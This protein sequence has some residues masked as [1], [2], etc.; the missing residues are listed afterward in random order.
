MPSTTKFLASAALGLALAC[1]A[2]L[3]G[4]AKDGD[5]DSSGSS[6]GDALVPAAACRPLGAATAV[7]TGAYGGV[8]AVENGAA[9]DVA[10]PLATE[11]LDGG[12]PVTF[13]VAYVD[14][15]A[16][17]AGAGVTAQ[18][19][20]T[21]YDA[22]AAQGYKETPVPGCKWTSGGS[23]TF[24]AKASFTC[25]AGLAKGEFYHLHVGLAS[26]ASAKAAL[27]GVAATR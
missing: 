27:I 10:C 6:S 5:D 11:D 21:S 15:D 17:A 9:A 12:K 25:K 19:V 24:G 4:H 14:G 8:L 23:S 26:T 20:R 2:P 13:Q 22:A 16:A 3:A 7:A 18:L 1:L